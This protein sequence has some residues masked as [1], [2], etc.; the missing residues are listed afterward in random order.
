MTSSLAI[1][2]TNETS[3]VDSRSSRPRDHDASSFVQMNDDITTFVPVFISAARPWTAW[4]RSGPYTLR[5]PM[6]S[7]P[8]VIFSALQGLFQTLCCPSCENLKH[9]R[10]FEPRLD[11]W[12]DHVRVKE[13]VPSPAGTFRGQSSLETNAQCL[14]NRTETLLRSVPVH[15]YVRVLCRKVAQPAAAIN[16]SRVDCGNVMVSLG[17]VCTVRAREL[18]SAHP[19]T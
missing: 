12:A 5:V 16:L 10:H 2:P 4:Q 3:L 6:L 18:D 14:P 9:Q 7:C 17:G 11:R 15:R 8:S 13:C 1:T 19:D